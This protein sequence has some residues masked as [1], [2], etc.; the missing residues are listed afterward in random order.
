[1]MEYLNTIKKYTG[2]NPLW[3]TQN[4]RRKVNCQARRLDSGTSISHFALKR[5]AITVLFFT[6]LLIIGCQGRPSEKPAIHLN[7]SMDNQPKYRPQAVG[8]FFL[9]GSGMRV[10]VEG[11]VARGQLDVTSAYV[12][13]I[14]PETGDTLIK[15]PVPYTTENM[16]RGRERYNIYC[17]ICHGQVGDGTGTIIKKGFVVPPSFHADQIRNYSDGRIFDVITKGIRN[18]PKYADQIP[19]E[20]RWLIVNYVR[21]LQRSQNASLT[22]VPDDIRDKL[23]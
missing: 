19:V 15:S 11:T 23:K 8:A 16:V 21:A 4:S 10:P 9:N 12:T 13:G 22:D 14:D 17:A 5:L 6:V 18:M 3:L 1:M 2:V 20:D 7:P